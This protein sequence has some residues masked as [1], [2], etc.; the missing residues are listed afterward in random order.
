MAQQ[1]R[2]QNNVSHCI[3]L[4]YCVVQWRRSQC[5]GQVQMFH[6]GLHYRSLTAKLFVLF[7]LLLVQINKEAARKSKNSF[8]AL[9]I[10]GPVAWPTFSRT[11]RRASFLLKSLW[12]SMMD[13]NY[14]SCQ[15]SPI[16]DDGC[17]RG[18]YVFSLSIILSACSP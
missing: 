4:I 8:D 9:T 12:K 18:H 1:I 16:V 2:Q 6:T 17:G 13:S 11:L 7:L 14:L 3:G 10:E 5:R 15:L